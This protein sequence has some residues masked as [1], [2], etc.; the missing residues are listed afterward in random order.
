L[1]HLFRF[2]LLM[3]KW[4]I[5]LM[6]NACLSRA[7]SHALAASLTIRAFFVLSTEARVWQNPPGTT[8]F[9]RIAPIIGLVGL[10]EFPMA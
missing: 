8:C 6:L 10:A 1:V 7:S 5:W 9:G 2:A 4:I 3:S